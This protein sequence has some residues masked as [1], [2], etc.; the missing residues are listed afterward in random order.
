M[1]SAYRVRPPLLESSM[2]SFY[3][4]NVPPLERTIRI[5][6]GVSI[7]IGAIFYLSGWA[8]WLVAASAVGIAISGLVGFC[9]ACAAFGRKARQ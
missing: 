5:F 2:S 1:F 7:A 4:K 6:V 3:L 8:G 9:P